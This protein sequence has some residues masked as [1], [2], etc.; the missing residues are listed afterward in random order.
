M[1]AIIYNNIFLKIINYYTSRISAYIIKLGFVIV[2]ISIN[3][4]KFD[5]LFL[6]TYGIAIARFI[7]QNMIKKFDSLREYFC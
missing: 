2:K 4:Q 6:I 3:N 5:D 7:L 1:L